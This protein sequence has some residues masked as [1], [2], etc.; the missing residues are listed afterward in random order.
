VRGAKPGSTRSPLHASPRRKHPLARMLRAHQRHGVAAAPVSVHAWL[1]RSGG[2]LN[3]PPPNAVHL[4]APRPPPRRGSARSPGRASPRSA[5][6][7]DGLQHQRQHYDAQVSPRPSCLRR[8][9]P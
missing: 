1:G 8:Q 4:S 2:K 9:G 6:R 5:R 7:Y 3:A